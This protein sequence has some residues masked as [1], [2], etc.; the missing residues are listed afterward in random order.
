MTK[1][2]PKTASPGAFRG[3]VGFFMRKKRWIGIV[4]IAVVAGGALAAHAREGQGRAEGRP[5][6][7]RLGKVQA[8]DLQVTRPRGRRRRPRDQ[9]G[10][11]VG[12]L[13]PRRRPEGPRGRRRQVGR[14]ARRGRARREPGAV[15]LRR[16]GGRHAGQ[17]LKLQDA[18][19]ELATQKALFDAGLIGARHLQRL[20]DQARPGRGEPRA[21]PRCATRSSRTTASRS[22]ATPRRRTRASTAP[23]SGVV[24]KKGVELGETVTSGVSSFNAGHRA[25]HGRRPRS[26]S[27]SAST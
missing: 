16:P 6:P 22:P 23:M 18:E 25:L 5:S 7:F 13:G 3:F 24:I 26:R 1:N 14:H 11:Q 4:A 15:A 17:E 19:R 2:G 27:S 9:G 12:R 20:G 8:E 10:R 21:P